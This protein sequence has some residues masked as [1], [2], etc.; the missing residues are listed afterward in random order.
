MMDLDEDALLCDFAE[1]YHIYDPYEYPCEYTATLAAGLRDDS[2]IKVRLS[3][4]RV[5]PELFALCT[6]V[7]ALRWIV[8]SKSEDGRKGRNRPQS[9]LDAL[10]GETKTKKTEDLRG[11]AT[12]EDFLKEW[13][14]LGEEV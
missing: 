12:G 1:T 11:F 5:T 2:R 3:G 7:D 10:S 6:G 13:N 4:L 8:W 14:R 9:I